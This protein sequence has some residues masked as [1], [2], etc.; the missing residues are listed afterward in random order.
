MI[1]SA[2]L[3]FLLMF[4]LFPTD[5]HN[6]LIILQR[7]LSLLLLQFLGSQKSSHNSESTAEQQIIT[8]HQFAFISTGG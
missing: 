6:W 3:I 8:E 1:F 2:T 4:K 7:S 5:E